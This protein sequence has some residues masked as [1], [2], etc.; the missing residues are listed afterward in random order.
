MFMSGLMS[1]NAERIKGCILTTLPKAIRTCLWM[2]KITIPIS[3]CVRIAQYVG[4]MEYVGMLTSAVFPLMGLPS[5]A[6]IVFFTSCFLPIYAPIALMATMELT[7]KQ[8]TI[9]SLMCLASHNLPVECAVASKT[10]SSFWTILTLRIS[11]SFIMAIIAN[12]L[13]P[14]SN[15]IF[16]MSQMGIDCGSLLE[17]LT[18]WLLASWNLIK[19]L[20]VIVTSL[21]FVQAVLEE[22]GVIQKISKIVSPIIRVVGLP[23]NT[24]FLWLV[25]NIVG[26]SYGSA[27]MIGMAS[28]GK[29]NPYEADLVN[30]HL[31]VN[32]SILEDTFLFS[33]L[34][35]CVW[36][37][38]LFRIPLAIFVVW[39]KR[40][41]WNRIHIKV[42]RPSLIIKEN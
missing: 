30:R 2:L 3:L 41:K 4:I 16:A 8:A 26:L 28:E 25:G 10:G 36:W 39:A 32:H 34:G 17:V 42:L 22:F 23:E 31:A 11:A 35:I 18:A 38:L 5:E 21:M 13:L 12:I 37:L 9:L 27:I 14:E 20:A 6:S 7:I 29:I 33:A 1:N 19:M 40:V 15:T 24:T